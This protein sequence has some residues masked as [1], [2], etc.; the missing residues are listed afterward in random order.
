MIRVSLILCNDQY[1]ADVKLIN[2]LAMMTEALSLCFN[3]TARGNPDSES[4]DIETSATNGKPGSNRQ[5]QERPREVS[6]DRVMLTFSRYCTYKLPR[7]KFV[8]NIFCSGSL[9]A[10]TLT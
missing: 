7:V 4:N 1:A 8:R 3:V 6:D 9:Y 2:C 5:H 10:V